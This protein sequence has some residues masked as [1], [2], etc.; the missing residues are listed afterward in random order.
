[1]KR[2]L[3]FIF[4]FSFFLLSNVLI[5]Q[6]IEENIKSQINKILKYEVDIDSDETPGCII[7]II[8]NGR[9]FVVSFG[10][11]VESKD[12]IDSSDYFDLGGLSKI[13]VSIV[14]NLLLHNEVFKNETE[15]QEI[16]PDWKDKN[17]GKITFSQLLTHRSGLPRELKNVNAD[18]VNQYENTSLQ[19]VME[20]LENTEL[21]EKKFLYSHYNYAIL[22]YWI[23]TT[24]NQSIHEIFTSYIATLPNL[25]QL[26]FLN[27]SKKNLDKN[28][29]LNKVGVKEYG[30]NYGAMENSLGAQN[31]I[32]DLIKLV[33]FFYLAEENAVR[34]RIIAD[35]KDT[36][37]DKTIKFSNGM[38]V[39]TGDKN[40][41]VYSH[42]GKSNRHS[43]AIHFVPETGTGVVI[44]SNSEVGTKDLS[45]QVLRMIND[46]WKRKP[47]EQKK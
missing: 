38:Y 8:D 12:Q 22:S 42:S 24:M 44:F 36:E 33:Q 1:M 14:A 10:N 43:S 19:E 13:Y 40:Y 9:T 41:S 34:D 28:L 15:L 27:G 6:E 25:E 11:K 20:S 2:H 4:I 7:A 17:I 30:L 37:I 21:G 46:N 3:Q 29:G 47:N 45:L 18:N 23:E 39:L 35:L 5:A 16:L 31:K 32:R 26:D